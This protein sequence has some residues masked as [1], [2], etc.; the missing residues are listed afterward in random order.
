MDFNQAIGF[1]TPV[2]ASYF[3][4]DL[5]VRF[6]M[7]TIKAQMAPTPPF[8]QN[9]LRRRMDEDTMVIWVAFAFSSLPHFPNVFPVN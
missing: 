9:M 2:K 8:K 5:P 7:A 3:K 1:N 4:N 6:N